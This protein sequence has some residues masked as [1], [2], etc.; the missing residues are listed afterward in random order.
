MSWDNP[1]L[2]I[3]TAFPVKKKVCHGYGYPTLERI[4]HSLPNLLLVQCSFHTLSMPLNANAENAQ[5]CDWN[6]RAISWNRTVRVAQ[7]HSRSAERSARVW[8]HTNIHTRPRTHSYVL[9]MWRTSNCSAAHPRFICHW[10]NYSLCCEYQSAQE[11]D[12]TQSLTQ[13][14]RNE[15]LWV[16]SV[17]I[18]LYFFLAKQFVSLSFHRSFGG[19]FPRPCQYFWLE[20][21]I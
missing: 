3:S 6:R 4:N 7:T 16:Q 2:V 17:S 18:T 21:K 14:T 15:F 1:V 11:T 19:F 12:A 13:G 8:M 5:H 9:E 10:A 20:M